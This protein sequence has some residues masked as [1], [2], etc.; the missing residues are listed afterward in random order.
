MMTEHIMGD[1]AP[2]PPPESV[3]DGAH[4]A[5]AV[6]RRED[7]DRHH[8]EAGEKDESHSEAPCVGGR[9]KSPARA[10]KFRSSWTE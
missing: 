10:H 1:L 2:D 6:I 3:Q 7:R 8:G 9:V 4:E 5:R